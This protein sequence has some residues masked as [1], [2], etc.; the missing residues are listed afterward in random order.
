[1]RAAGLAQPPRLRHDETKGDEMS[2]PKQRHKLG[3]GHGQ[4]L[5]YGDGTF[6]YQ[7][8]GAML[9]LPSFRVRPGDIT[10]FAV[11]K[12]TADDRKRLGA[13]RGQEILVILGLGAT[14]AETPVNAGTGGKIEAWFRARP[15]FGVSSATTPP[16]PPSVPA[17]WYPDAGNAALQRYWDGAAWTAHTAPAAPLVRVEFDNWRHAHRECRALAYP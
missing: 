12:A 14:L 5:E 3:F 17:G 6:S 9:T 10:G 7:P 8:M 2:R 11:R 15:E 13:S 16:P 1:M 4:M